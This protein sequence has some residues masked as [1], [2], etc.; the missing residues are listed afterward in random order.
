MNKM[1]EMTIKRLSKHELEDFYDRAVVQLSP[2]LVTSLTSVIVE[3]I[4]RRK[5]EN[6]GEIEFV[7]E[8]T[9]KWTPNKIQKD[10]FDSLGYIPKNCIEYVAE[11]EI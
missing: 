1:K 11:E 9:G 4:Q 8:E 5:Q 6:A 2:E 10:L 3:L 7:V